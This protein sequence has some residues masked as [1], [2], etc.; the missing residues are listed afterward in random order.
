MAKDSGLTEEQAK[1]IDRS[2]EEFR[3]G[4]VE[5][6]LGEIALAEIAQKYGLQL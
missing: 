4:K 3:S 5:A 1:E 6:I 2:P